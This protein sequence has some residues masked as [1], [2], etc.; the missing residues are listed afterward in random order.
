MTKNWGDNRF[1]KLIEEFI[2]DEVIPVDKQS[3]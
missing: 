2:I 1:F 3:K